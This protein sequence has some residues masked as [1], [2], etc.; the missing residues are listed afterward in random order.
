MGLRLKFNLV[1]IVVF[2][3]GFAAAGFIS[4]QLLQENARDEV[5]RN[6]R[7]MMDTALAVRAYT[8][9]QIKPQL[10]PRLEEVFLPQTVPA[11]A[12]TETLAHI[13]KKYRDYAYKE[14]A[15]NPTNPRDR[16]TDWESDL[17]QQFRQNADIKEL[18]SERESATGRLLYI[19]KPIQITNPACLRCHSVPAAA[20]ATM[21]KIYG[22]ANGFGWKH[23]E[24][25]GAQ[26]VTVPMNIPIANADRALKTFMASLA[27]VFVVF[28]IVLNV[29]LSW[30]I[31]RPIRRMSLSADQVSTG[32]FD[33]PEFAEGG[34]DEV[35]ILGSSF[36]RLRRSI[37]KAMQMI[38]RGA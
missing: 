19:A 14:A 5:L 31:I 4:R 9:D 7:L 28:F 26:V 16:S 2:L 11:F 30:F 35:S 37:E 25:I 24:I 22:E 15:L 21:L 29:M 3:A 1:L 38:E 36:N 17:V 18:V 13:Q 32:N 34:K 33:V 20:P 27:G 12:A 23:N 6:A 8:V 10:D